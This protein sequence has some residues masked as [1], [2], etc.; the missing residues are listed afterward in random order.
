MTL[1]GVPSNILAVTIFLLLP[2]FRKTSALDV[3]TGKAGGIGAGD[4]LHGL[5]GLNGATA[6]DQASGK[7]KIQDGHTENQAME[8][9]SKKV[10]ARFGRQRPSTSSNESGRKV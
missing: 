1:F 2:R 8:E 5:A 4:G 3:A 6:Q 10:C 7:Q 9:C